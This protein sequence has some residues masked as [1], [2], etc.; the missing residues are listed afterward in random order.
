M[1]ELGSRCKQQPAPPHA[2]FEAL[3]EPHRDPSRPWLV[4]LPDEQ[5]PQVLSAQPFTE[6]IW[7]S[8]WPH[9]Q[10]LQIRFDLDGDRSGTAL[11][12]TLATEQPLADDFAIGH[13]RKR[14]NVLI[15]AELRYSFG[16]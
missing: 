11:R 12:W 16:Q 6:V 15:N 8:L 4:L 1:Y 13:M 9:R 3:V 5:A 10:E 7:S 2:V 14:L